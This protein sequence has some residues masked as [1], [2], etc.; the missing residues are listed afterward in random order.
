MGGDVMCIEKVD[1]WGA[2]CYP[3]RRWIAR[4]A[5]RQAVLELLWEHSRVEKH[6]SRIV[7]ADDGYLRPCP[8]MY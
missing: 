8:P 7:K 5:D 1:Y 3:C 2:W 6:F 4:G